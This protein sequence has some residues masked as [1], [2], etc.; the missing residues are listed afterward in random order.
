[1]TSPIRAVFFDLYDTL[2][3]F[4]PPR[5]IIQGR[6]MEPFGMGSNKSGIDAGY[7]LADAL[8]AEQTAQAPLSALS[9]DAQSDFFAH[10]EQLVLRGAGHDVD[11]KTAGDVWKAVR[12]Q[13]YGFALYDDVTPVL[14][15]LRS[16]GFVVGVVTNMSRP[17]EDVASSMGFAG[18]V[19]FTL[20]SMD[21]GASKPDPKMFQAALSRAGV[22]ADQ[23]AHVGDQLETDIDGARGAGINPVLI[24][25]HSAAIDYD[26]CPRITTLT[27][28]PDVLESFGS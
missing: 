20:S 8:M 2:I 26:A 16:D 1:M 12:K 10:Y 15:G 3:G 13:E 14:D 7:A 27:E 5:E 23:A 19:D 21:V 22:A 6:A 4:D 11:L 9:P 24:D 25:R 18:N 28:L 17:G